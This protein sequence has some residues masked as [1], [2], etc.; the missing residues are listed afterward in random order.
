MHG[1][2]L[3][4]LRRFLRPRSV[5]VVPPTPP[6][7]R[8]GGKRQAGRARL[9]ERNGKEVAPVESSVLEELRGKKGKKISSIL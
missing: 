8:K 1:V 7:K 3:H 4:A 2:F 6:P 9:K 5:M